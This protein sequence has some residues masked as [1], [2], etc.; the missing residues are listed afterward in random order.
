MFL[1]HNGIQPGSDLRQASVNLT[2]TRLEMMLWSSNQLYP[3]CKLEDF[4]GHFRSLRVTYSVYLAGVVLSFL[5]SLLSR[6][7]RSEKCTIFF[8]K[9]ASEYDCFRAFASIADADVTKWTRA[10]DYFICQMLF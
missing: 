2:Q 5:Y 1:T 9:D 8:G 6:C 3:L 4:E 7:F 10:N